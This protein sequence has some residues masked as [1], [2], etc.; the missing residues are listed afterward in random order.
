M[1]MHTCVA[2]VCSGVY[3]SSVLMHVAVVNSSV[4]V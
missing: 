4:R 1:L 3:S 2:V